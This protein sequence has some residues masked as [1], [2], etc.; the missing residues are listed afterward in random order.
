MGKSHKVSPHSFAALLKCLNQRVPASVSK[1]KRKV[2][3]TDFAE[4][5]K[6]QKPSAVFDASASSAQ[7][8]SVSLALPGSILH[9]AQTEEL[10]TQLA[11]QVRSSLHTEMHP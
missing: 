1:Q 2:S 8:S 6:P 9:N 7:S 11:G 3:E 10:R 5:A 4:T